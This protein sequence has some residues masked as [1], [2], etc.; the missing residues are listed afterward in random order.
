MP[1]IKRVP[2]FIN[3]PCPLLPECEITAR[4]ITA[5]GAERGP[6]F[7]EASLQFAQCLWRQ[8]LPA[9]A[10][11]QL[12]RALA[13]ALGNDEPVLARWPLPYSAMIYFM[14]VR[15]VGQFI[16]NPR[17]HFQHLATRM[18]EPNK[19]LRTWRAWACWYA[20][21]SLLPEDGYPA[22]AKQ[23]R[24]EGIIEPTFATIREQL[25]T[26]S[27][28][29]DV[30]VWE[31]ALREAGVATPVSARAAIRV[32]DDDELS[33][34]RS[35]AHAIWPQVYP[36]IISMEQIHYMLTQRYELP[37]LRA[38]VERGVVYALILNVQNAA[39]GYTAFEPRPSSGD[40]FL[41]KLYLLPEVAGKGFGAAALAWVAQ[42]ARALGLRAVRLCVNKQ[43][44][45][46][47]RA[48][49]RSGF[50]FEEDV[51]TQIGDGFVMD[52]YVMKLPLA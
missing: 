52:D 50:G 28:S 25:R 13:C 31:Q 7:Y 26:W 5:L 3:E 19:V 33:M 46:A 49:L 8:G 17:R 48:Y 21:K 51:I 35:L 18:V 41:H 9:Q 6:A 23:I 44:H 20:A 10:M 43:N 34:V 29:N 12:T 40:A 22:D 1:R 30:E 42:Q 4:D 27:P 11:L 24:E 32:I 47:V 39:V 2:E 45:A 16:G 36:S 38:D 14:R 37:V 15:A